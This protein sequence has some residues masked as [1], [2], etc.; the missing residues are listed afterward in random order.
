MEVHEITRN[1]RTFFFLDGHVIVLV[2]VPLNGS[3]YRG[4]KDESF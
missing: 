2:V 1:K 4:C 3:W